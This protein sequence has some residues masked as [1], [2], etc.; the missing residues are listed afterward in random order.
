MLVFLSDVPEEDGG[1][2]LHFPKL[3]LATYNIYIYYI[4]YI[5]IYYKVLEENDPRIEAGYD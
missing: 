2:H 1:G 3:G 4:I 5:Y